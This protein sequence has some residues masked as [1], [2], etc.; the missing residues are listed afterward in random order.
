[1][2]HFK[3]GAD[4]AVPETPQKSG[5][6]SADRREFRLDRTSLEKDQS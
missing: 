4:G 1:M 2:H 3:Q 5:Q 6:N